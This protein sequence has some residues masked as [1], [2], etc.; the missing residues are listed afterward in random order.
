MQAAA[1]AVRVVRA[2]DEVREAV[3]AATHGDRV[4]DEKGTLPA[5]HQ[6]MGIHHARV[7]DA[8]PAIAAQSNGTVTEKGWGA[9]VTVS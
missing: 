2:L 5:H 8:E 6:A 7:V 3:A 4:I 9:R 1:G